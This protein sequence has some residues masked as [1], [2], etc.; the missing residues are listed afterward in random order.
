M[1]IAKLFSSKNRN[2]SDSDDDGYKEFVDQY[3]AA[4]CDLW[5]SPLERFQYLRNVFHGEALRFYN[6]N[7]VGRARDFP[8]SL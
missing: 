8:E 1:H 6:T 3:L 2:Y 5:L 7:I 4:S